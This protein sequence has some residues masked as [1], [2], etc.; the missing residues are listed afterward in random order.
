MDSRIKGPFISIE[1]RREPVEQ[2]RKYLPKD[3]TTHHG[4]IE[5][6]QSL[7]GFAVVFIFPEGMIETTR[8]HYRALVRDWALQKND[9]TYPDCPLI[10]V[11]IAPGGKP[12]GGNEIKR[13]LGQADTVFE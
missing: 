1:C 7:A 13:L 12:W 8:A 11:T 10:L 3:I 9:G 4:Y 6:V 5:N 2:S